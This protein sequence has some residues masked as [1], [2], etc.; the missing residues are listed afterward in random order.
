MKRALLFVVTLGLF[1]VAL[2]G[3][4]GEAEIDVD[5]AAAIPAMR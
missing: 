4:R 5:E 3:C 2:V 1:S